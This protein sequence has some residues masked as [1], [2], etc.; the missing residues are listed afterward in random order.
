MSQ[1][2]IPAILEKTITFRRLSS[3]NV[4]AYEV[5]ATYN[6]QQNLRTELLDTIPNPSYP[7]P[8]LTEIELPYNENA[9]WQLPHD[10]FLDRDH[11]FRLYLNGFILS[12]MCYNYNRIQKLISLDIVMKKYEIGDKLVLKYYKDII[13]KKY[14]V[15]DDCKITIKPIFR[16][17]YEYGFHNV[18][19]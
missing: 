14:A 19:I 4:V 7:S 6:N 8:V 2:I 18:I 10:A 15:T 13:T 3:K 16:D 1:Y 5:Y 12:N 17:G 11:Q 9:T